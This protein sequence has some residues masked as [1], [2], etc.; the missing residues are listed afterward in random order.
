MIREDI[1]QKIL[2]QKLHIDNRGNFYGKKYEEFTS[3]N[4]GMWQTPEE[5]AGLLDYLQYKDDINTF[6][7]IG[8]FNGVTF[9]FIANF[10]NDI[11]PVECITMD[12]NNYKPNKDERFTYLLC[13]VDNFKDRYFDLVF[14][15]GDHSYAGAKKDY[16]TVGINAK[17]VVFHDIDDQFVEGAPQNNGGVPRLWNEIKN[18]RNFIEFIDPEKEVRHMG[19]GLLY[20][21]SIF[22]REDYDLR[23]KKRDK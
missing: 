13:D 5:L 19:I 8:T 12:I 3:T 14:I 7:N 1:V 18:T 15:D 22:Q 6:L 4:S 16:D 21:E 2:E 11:Q 23:P 9:N 17:Y 20:G 10:L